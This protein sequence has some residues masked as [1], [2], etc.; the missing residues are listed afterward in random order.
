MKI[1]KLPTLKKVKSGRKICSIWDLRSLWD[2]GDLGPLDYGLLI[3]DSPWSAVLA[4]KCVLE[5][6]AI[7]LQ[8]VSP[9]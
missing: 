6:L 2:E 1:K 8:W 4:K 3:S 9:A 5:L 7:V